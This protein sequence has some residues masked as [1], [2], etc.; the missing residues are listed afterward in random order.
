MK[1]M[2]FSIWLSTA[3][4][5]LLNP[6]WA[7]QFGNFTY[8]DNGTSITITDYPTNAVGPVT[9]PSTIS[10]K[11]VTAI[12]ASAFYSCASI[13]S[14]EIPPGVTSIGINAFRYCNALTDLIVP[15]GVATIG[16]WAFAN[17][18]S[19]ASV[20]MPATVTSAG[21]AAFVG[22]SGLASVTISPNLTNIGQALFSSCSGLTSVVIP[23]GITSIDGLA[24]YNCNKLAEVIMPSGIT[25]IGG[26]AFQGCASLSRITIPSGVTS[27]GERAFSG[28]MA[29]EEFF[30]ETANPSFSSD[31]GVIFNKSKTKLILY[32]QGKIGAYTVPVGVSTIGRF[33]FSGSAKLSEITIP[34][35]V[36]SI[37]YA[38]FSSCLNLKSVTI[39]GSVNSIAENA[40]SGCNELRSACFL[41][42]APTTMG[43]VDPYGNAVF[44]FSTT[45]YYFNGATGFTSPT[46]LG[47]S[48]VNMGDFSFI[49]PWLLSNGL[50]YNADIESDLN[51]DGVNLLTAYSLN[52]NPNQNLAG[53]LPRPAFAGG[54]MSLTFYAGSP[55]VTYK[56]E[57]SR[58]LLNWNTLG[59]TLSAPDANKF[60]TATVSTADPSRYLRLVTDY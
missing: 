36:V 58:D 4:F 20:T 38:A 50:A 14:V 53:S 35:G 2:N 33:A 10:G 1:R 18:S 8:T 27:I 31:D 60:R 13:T 34:Q 15:D 26:L 17:C 12:G 41:G 43:L 39:P 59:V 9:I 32:P 22:C 23:S 46:W 24:F 19:L 25:S 47:F 45:V 21:I 28:C 3:F 51:N 56:V 29:M 30:V 48:S 44:P 52:L 6:L 37:E 57:T 5:C 16:D 11:P 7:D 49:A 42:N 40:F 55:G 54:Q